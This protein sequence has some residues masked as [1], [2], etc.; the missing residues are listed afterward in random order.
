MNETVKEYAKTHKVLTLQITKKNFNDI[1]DGIQ[2]VEHRYIYPSN[3]NRYVIQEEEFDKNGEFVRMLV[4]PVHYDALYLIN[5][6]RKE[7]PRMLIKVEDAEFILC[8][9]EDGNE[10]TFEQEGETYYECQVWYHLG[11]VLD[12]ENC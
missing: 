3:A 7:A 8:V 1:K 10:L 2:K 9:D 4:T 6:R 11:K 5:G 12:L